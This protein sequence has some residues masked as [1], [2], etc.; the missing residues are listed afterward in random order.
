[1]EN[2]ESFEE[3]EKEREKKIS[4]RDFLKLLGYTA[5][6]VAL[7]HPLLEIFKKETEEKREVKEE[8]VKESVSESPTEEQERI[9][10]HNI[11]S[12]SEVLDYEKEGDIKL[13]TETMEAIKNH[14]KERYSDSDDLKRD[15]V[16]A[17]SEMGEWEEYLKE[18]FEKQ[19]IPEKYIYLAIPESHWRMDALSHARAKGPYQFMPQ[20][21]RSYGLKTSYFKDHPQNLEERMDPIKSARACAE[22]LRDLY[23]ASS[24]WNMALSG[25]NGGFFWRYLKEARNKKENASYEGFLGFLEKRINK[26]KKEVQEKGQRRYKIETGDNMNAIAKKFDK[27]VEE[28]CQINGIED[29]NQIHAGQEI[30]IPA[31]KEGKKELFKERIN[32]MKENLNYPQKFNAVYELIEEGLLEGKERKDTVIF[33]EKEIKESGNKKHV[34]R[35]KDKSFYSLALNFPG[36]SVED[37]IKANPHLRHDNLREGDEIIIPGVGGRLTLE[38]VAIENG[39]DL[40]R[41]KKLNPAIENPSL[42]IPP[43]HKIRV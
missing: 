30:I 8:G 40:E 2:F 33:R 19:K 13:D 27:D 31:S 20:T 14:W 12:L 9:E 10:E 35:K 1:M 18:E 17:Y 43:G 32:G 7:S 26:I 37:I 24:D 28:L 38:G 4:R 15:L 34:F 11:N 6:G 41:L 39:V 23:K 16:W 5:G 29:S 22:L 21:A 36:V 42:A 25:Y 3:D